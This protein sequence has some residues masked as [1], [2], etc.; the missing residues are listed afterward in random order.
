MVKTPGFHCRSSG[1]IPGWGTKILH[2]VLCGKKGGWEVV[3]ILQKS[4]F[5]NTTKVNSQDEE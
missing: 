2:T 5:D 3:V 1:L 4:F